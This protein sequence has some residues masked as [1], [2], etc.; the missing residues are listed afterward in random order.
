MNLNIPRLRAIEG[1]TG[2]IQNPKRMLTR[3]PVQAVESFPHPQESLTTGKLTQQIHPKVARDPTSCFQFLGIPPKGE[4]DILFDSVEIAI[5]S[6]QFLGIPP[7]GE[8][9]L[10]LADCPR[11]PPLRFQFLGIP[12]KG[13]QS[14]PVRQWDYPE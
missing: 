12:P 7:K 9:A 3:Q 10:F 8:Q 11:L 4:L 2:N 1:Y 13:E 6:F 5:N 14:V